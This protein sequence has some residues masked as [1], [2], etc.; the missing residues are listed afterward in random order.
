MSGMAVFLFPKENRFQGHSHAKERALRGEQNPNKTPRIMK[1][2]LI[3]ND[4]VHR[5]WYYYATAA[6]LFSVWQVTDR[7]TM[8]EKVGGQLVRLV[9]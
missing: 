4:G 2:F 9:C 1:Y 5:H 6:E 7:S 3:V 8:W